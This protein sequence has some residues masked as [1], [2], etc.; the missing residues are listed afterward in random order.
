MKDTGALKKYE[1][2]NYTGSYEEM[3]NETNFKL[4]CGYQVDDEYVNKLNKGEVIA[5]GSSFFDNPLFTDIK[6]HIIKKKDKR[7]GLEE[8]EKPTF[9]PAKAMKKFS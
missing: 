7:K 2:M 4:D 5:K 8:L 3:I 6:K 1:P 9:N